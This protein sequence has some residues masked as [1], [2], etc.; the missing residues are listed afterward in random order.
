MWKCEFT[1]HLGPRKKK[2]VSVLFEDETEAIEYKKSVIHS[3]PEKFTDFIIVPPAS[4]PEEEL[5]E[6]PP[7]EEEL[8]FVDE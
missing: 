3:D 7:S 6:P 4:A 2:R 5:V 8:E 1:V